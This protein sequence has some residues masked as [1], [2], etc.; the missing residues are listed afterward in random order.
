VRRYLQVFFRHPLLLSAPVVIALAASLTIQLRA[1]AKYMA[2][3]TLWADAPIPNESTIVSATNPTPSV[4]QAGVLAE[5]LHTHDFLV[6]VGKRSPWATYLASQ[7]PAVADR[8]V[9]GLS[10][11]VVITEPGSQVINVAV[12]SNTADS[13]AGLAKA[14]M[15]EFV[16]E[17]VATRQAR[18]KSLTDYYKQRVDVAAKS[19]SDAQ[20]QIGQYLRGRPAT[21]VTGTAAVGTAE[22]A[23]ATQLAGTI[24]LAQQQLVDAQNNFAKA[25][26]D[27]AHAADASQL[28]VIDQ[29]A[30]PTAP[31]SA[32]KKVIFAGVG[33]LLAGSVISLMVLLLF[34]AMDTTARDEADIEGALGLHVIGSIKQVPS[35]R[36]GRRVS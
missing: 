20:G 10:R 30:V 18:G 34:V 12:K 23:T 4:T 2:Q 32:K 11:S 33:G 13:A 35:R 31:Q 16:D 22:D 25:S 5:L 19:L 17:V 1:P 3:G 29:P 36:W 28:H 6:K 27:L 24:A 26:L 14:V 15:N 7:P 9:D 8:V 21:G